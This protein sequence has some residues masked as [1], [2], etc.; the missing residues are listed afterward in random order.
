[1]SQVIEL[2]IVVSGMAGL[3]EAIA[4]AGLE[5]SRQK[6]FATDQGKHAVDL[7]IKDEQGTQTGVSLDKRTGEATF[8]AHGEKGGALAHRVMQRYAYSRVMSELKRKGYQ[9]GKEEKQ[10]DG[11]I[12]L[13]AQRWR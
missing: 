12:R 7:V 8:I 2:K 9:I 1:M 6:T 5:C 10:K 13:V 4:E 11:S 3:L